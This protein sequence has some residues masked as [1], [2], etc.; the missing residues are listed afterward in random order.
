MPLN[1]LGPVRSALVNMPTLA[2]WRSHQDPKE[3]ARAIH[4]GVSVAP[5]PRPNERFLVRFCFK[6][7][8]PRGSFQYRTRSGISKSAET[9]VQP[10]SRTKQAFTNRSVPHLDRPDRRM[11]RHNHEFDIT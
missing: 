7:R 9:G 8:L 4:A 10:V 6:G 1:G 3:N 2:A 5:L 11:A